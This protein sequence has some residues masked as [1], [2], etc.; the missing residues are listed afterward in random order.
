MAGL[1]AN[2]T[3]TC[4]QQDVDGYQQIVAICYA[5]GE[6][7]YGALWLGDGKQYVAA[8]TGV[9][10]AVPISICYTSVRRNRASRMVTAAVPIMVCSFLPK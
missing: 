4:E 6:D 10:A 1:L 2:H 3:V 8:E 9:T 5:S 7:G